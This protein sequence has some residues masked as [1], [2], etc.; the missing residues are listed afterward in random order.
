MYFKDRNKYCGLLKVFKMVQFP[1]GRK[2]PV[3][4]KGL[5]L[6]P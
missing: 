5:G 6:F 2:K 4:I 1:G 3:Q